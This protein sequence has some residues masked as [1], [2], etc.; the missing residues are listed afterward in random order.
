M[1]S[2]QR[3]TTVAD[4]QPQLILVV[5]LPGTGKTTLAN[6][7]ARRLSAAYLRIDAI[8]TA[9]QVVRGDHE[10]VG[11]E[12]YVVAHFLARS[13]LAV[14][15]PVVVDAVCP[16]PESRTGWA[17]TAATGGGALVVLETSLPDVGE[18]RR[19]V[20]DRLPDMPGQQV[21]AWDAVQSLDWT[22]WDEDRDGSRAI[23]DTTDSA[24]AI[25]AAME[26]IH[27]GDVRQASGQTG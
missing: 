9:I 20:E 7:L 4:V 3:R 8:E 5:G 23:I 18:H 13:N 1:R 6:G 27:G 2:R 12:G 21:P 22:P 10:Q 14:G 17:D 25:V 24:D 26:V 19:R 15:R 11:V 16:V